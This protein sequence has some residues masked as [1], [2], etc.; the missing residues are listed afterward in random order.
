MMSNRIKGQ[1]PSEE[2]QIRRNV[3][4]SLK[5]LMLGCRIICCILSH[6]WRAAKLNN[7][8]FNL[9]D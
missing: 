3:K 2:R 8:F 6:L 4:Y 1:A 9:S 5:Y 7:D